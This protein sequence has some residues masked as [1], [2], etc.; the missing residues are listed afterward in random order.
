MEKK[1]SV[2]DAKR[3]FL[4]LLR[5]VRGGQSFVVTTRGRAVARIAPVDD[6]RA[7]R[8]SAR[9]F[10]LGRLRSEAVVRIG[11]WKRDELYG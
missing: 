3:R 11:R 9:S 7:I 4:R 10:L 8:A 6:G 1:I 2:T 5:D